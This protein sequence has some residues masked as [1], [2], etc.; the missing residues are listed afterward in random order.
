MVTAYCLISV[1]P[2]KI[3]EILPKVRTI[4]AVKLVDSV[5]GEYDVVTRIEVDSLKALSEIVFGEIRDI[6]G[7]TGTATLIVF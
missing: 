1:A 6:P 5:A 2:G 4:D 7:V 3:K